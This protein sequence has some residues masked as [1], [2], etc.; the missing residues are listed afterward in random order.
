MA[1]TEPMADSRDKIVVHTMPR[2]QSSD[3]RAGERGRA[4]SRVLT[5][6]RTALLRRPQ[7]DEAGALMATRLD[8]SA[9]HAH[10]VSNDQLRHG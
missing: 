2:K 4:R 8:H 6:L 5:G 1:K 3:P 7:F 9:R 10:T